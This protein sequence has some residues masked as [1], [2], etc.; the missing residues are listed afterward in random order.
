MRAFAFECFP[1]WN[2]GATVIEQYSRSNSAAKIGAWNENQYQIGSP[3]TECARLKRLPLDSRPLHLQLL[4]LASKRL[5]AFALAALSLATGPKWV[6]P[7][8]CF[9]QRPPVD[10]SA[11]KR[12]T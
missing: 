1:D 4:I 10:V 7:M 2:F 11:R 6:A 8:E 3:R 9:L 5:Q 12:L